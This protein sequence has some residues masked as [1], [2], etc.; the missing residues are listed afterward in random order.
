[1][2]PTFGPILALIITWLN[3]AIS[4]SGQLSCTSCNPQFLQGEPSS[5]D[6]SC[7]AGNAIDLLPDF[8][9]YTSD[10]PDGYGTAVA[11]FPLGNERVCNG[12]RPEDLPYFLGTVH[13]HNFE[14]TGLANSDAFSIDGSGGTWTRYSEDIATF[15][16]RIINS[17]NTNL[18]FRVEL[19]LELSTSGASWMSQNGNINWAGS[20]WN[21][22]L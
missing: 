15:E 8:L 11:K 19:V 10:C 7:T 21:M 20:L 6:T 22:L 14:S 3:P 18:Q 2:R 1:M 13:L 16:G 4:A 17:L 9:E 5:L 12:N